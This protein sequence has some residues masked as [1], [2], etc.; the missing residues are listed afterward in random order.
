MYSLPSLI[1]SSLTRLFVHSLQVFLIGFGIF[2]SH[3]HS[4]SLRGGRAAVGKV[5]RVDVAVG[6]AVGRVPVGGVASVAPMVMRRRGRVIGAAALGGR[7]L[8]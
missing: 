2:F 4:H 6:V 1:D 8:R 7:A 3:S 5:P